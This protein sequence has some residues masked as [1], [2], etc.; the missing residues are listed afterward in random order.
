MV[1]HNPLYGI[2]ERN[3]IDYRGDLILP[4]PQQWF[5][6]I[7]NQNNIDLA[8]QSELNFLSLSM[9]KSLEPWS[10]SV[11]TLRI[12]LSC[13]KRQLTERCGI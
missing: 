7:T 3:I 6:D 8:D 5:L 2:R 9:F 4:N 13:G 10:F 1:P 12:K 11:L